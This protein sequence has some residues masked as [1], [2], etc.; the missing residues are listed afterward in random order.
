MIRLQEPIVVSADI[1]TAFDY[2]AEFESIERWDP[3]VVTAKKRGDQPASVGTAFDLVTVFKGT[4]SDM[5]Y[6]IT[7]MDRPHR[8][9]FVGEGKTTSAVD[10]LTFQESEAGTE[11]VYTADLTFRG[12]ARIGVKFLGT[13]LDELGKGAA[14]GLKDALDSL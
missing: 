2:V 10:T 11:I 6:T 9:V 5:V 3:G 1:E 13:A 7:E 12:L 4:E 8:I 14:N